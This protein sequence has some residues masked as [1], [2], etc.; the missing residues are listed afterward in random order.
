MLVPGVI[1]TLIYS[2]GPLAGLVMAFQDFI[3]GRGFFG[4]QEW[5]GFGNFILLSRM[6]YFWRALRNTVYIA[7]FKIVLGLLV[8]I[9][10]SLLINEVKKGVLFKRTIQTLFYLPHFISWV[11]LGG[12]LLD[13]LSPSSGIVNQLLGYLGISPIFF[14]GDNK[15]FPF[16]IIFTSIWKEFGWGTIIYLAAIT[17]IDPGLYES[18]VMDGA[19]RFQQIIHITLPGMAMIIVLR[20]VLSLGQV[21]NAGY[22]QIFNLY[23]PIVYETGDI[24][25][26]FIYRFGILEGRYSP[27]A[28]VGLF[29]SFVSLIF[30]TISYYSAYKFADYRVF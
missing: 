26:T 28:A 14:L 4:R 30:I 19:N 24:L 2:Y 10:F 22:D 1:L 8:P 25:D 29:K 7:F 17:S 18:A 11:V 21:L 13:V 12:I 15:W 5:V 6:D 9:I 27:A 20:S 16:T 3:P 23:N